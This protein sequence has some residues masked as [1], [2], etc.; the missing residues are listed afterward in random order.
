MLRFSNI[1][2]GFR[3]AILSGTSI[4]LVIGMV[5]ASMRNNAQVRQEQQPD[6]HEF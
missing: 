2:V 4:L 1:R 6:R 5:F 3:L